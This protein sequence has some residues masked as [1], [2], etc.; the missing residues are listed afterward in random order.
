ME[1][2]ASGCAKTQCL[3][4]G[5]ACKLVQTT[6]VVA[7]VVIAVTVIALL[8]VTCVCLVHDKIGAQVR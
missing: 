8:A 4:G 1:G 2:A 7:L 6:L 3:L 5:G